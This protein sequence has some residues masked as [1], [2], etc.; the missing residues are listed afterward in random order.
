MANNISNA[1]RA[2]AKLMMMRKKAQGGSN[3]SDADRARARVEAELIRTKR[4]EDL[5]AEGSNISDAD[6]ARAAAEEMYMKRN[7]GGIASKT[8]IF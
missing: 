3:I 4:I 6:R 8:R 7:D 2:R 5:L 1:D